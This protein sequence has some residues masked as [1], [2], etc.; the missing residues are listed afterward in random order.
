M[1]EG[2]LKLVLPPEDSAP[3][4]V[5]RWISLD[6][7]AERAEMNTGT[8]R[9]LCLEKWQHIG[10]AKTT[11]LPSGQQGW[12]VDEG[13][14]PRFA[15]AK[16]TEQLAR[17]FDWNTVPEKQRQIGLFRLQLLTDWR[18]A[19]KD[20]FARNQT[21]EQITQ[22]FIK[23]RRLNMS[24]R[25]IYR[26]DARWRE[27]GTPDG[28]LDG[29]LPAGKEQSSYEPFYA[30][31]KDLFLEFGNAKVSPIYRLAAR[32]ALQQGMDVPCLRQARR[33]IET[34]CPAEATYHRV[35]P[36]AF[37]DLYAA[38]CERDFTQIRLA[39]GF[40]E[41][42]K[43]IVRGMESNDIWCADHHICDAFVNDNG[44][45]IRP[46]LTVWQDMRSR[47]IVGYVW[48]KSTPNS[49]TVMLC[50]RDAIIRNGLSVPRFCYTDNGKDFDAWVFDGRTKRERRLKIKHDQDSFSGVYAQLQI[51]HIHAKP[52]NA[53]AKP[54]ERWFR[55]F[56]ESFNVFQPGYCGGGTAKKPERLADILDRGRVPDFD[57]YVH[58][59][60]AWIDEAYANQAHGGQGMDGKSPA[61]VYEEQLL[62]IRTT[63]TQ[64][65]DVCLMTASR[66][67]KV[68]RNGVKVNYRT[69]GRADPALRELVGQKVMLR[70]DPNDVRTAQ[71]WSADGK[72]R[73]C[74][75]T[76]NDL[77][78]FDTTSEPTFRAAIQE[79]AR[80]NRELKKIQ[81]RG[82][83]KIV[84]PTEILIQDAV[85]KARDA[86][87]P[88]PP[89][90][91]KVSMIQTG[92]DPASIS[93]Q[94][95]FKQ[96]AGGEVSPEK[97][98]LLDWAEED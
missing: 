29:R 26:L 86:A 98:L 22:A 74:L 85:A 23:S 46:W 59:A 28:L 97:S 20:R 70:F 1:S 69:Y 67:I 10:L 95:P 72:Q 63:T 51:G 41:K 91:R 96:A 18:A 27:M 44:Q 78:M 58:E 57:D 30:M 79:T 87:P 5:G 47:R 93:D 3:S 32:R 71:V 84:S 15:A 90:T 42:Q 50:L 56:E 82:M 52:Y 36:K 49:A 66:P 13:A 40:G 80:H 73:L 81:K 35:G 65:L 11:K 16:P 83:R 4:P 25:N 34:V 54:V 12:M 48:S 53:K 19:C 89:P 88:T 75:V 33:F 39:E 76:C 31:L 43:I 92:I 38:Y 55:T 21:Q 6:V 77:E 37:D 60:S 62:T 14:D 7:A 45:I 68:G 17:E 61:V 94:T 24:S 8:L 9:R 2:T 64:Q